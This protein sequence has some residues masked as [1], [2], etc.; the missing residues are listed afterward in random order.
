MFIHVPNSGVLKLRRGIQSLVHDLL[1]EPRDPWAEELRRVAQMGW[2]ENRTPKNIVDDSKQL[3]DKTLVSLTW[4]ELKRRLKNATAERGKKTA[5]ADFAGVDRSNMNRWLDDDQEPG[6][7]AAFRLLEWVTA[8]E[9][10]Q[11]SPDGALTPPEQMTP[12]GIQANEVP[13]SEPGKPSPGRKKKSTPQ[14]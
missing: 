3:A 1:K 11:K 10:K 9:A 2:I 12:K 4:K 8:E 7:E 5:A 13:N 14:R 6:A